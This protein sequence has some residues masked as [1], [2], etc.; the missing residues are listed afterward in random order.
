[1]KLRK[2][3]AQT[4]TAMIIV[5][6]FAAS[7]LTV[8]AA[9]SKTEAVGATSGTTGDCKW[10]L[11]NG[12]LT[13]SGD[14]AMKNY[15]YNNYLPW[16]NEVKS[17]I[18]ENG[19]T[20]IGRSVFYNCRNL[21]SVTIPGSVTSINSDAF[22]NCIGLTSI[23]IPDS[24]TSIGVGAFF[25]C[26][27]LTSVTIPDSVTSIGSAAFG[28]CT[29]LTS[30]TIPDSVT[31]IGG[32]AFYGT[33]W[34]NNQQDGLVYA[35]KAAYEYKGDMPENTSIVIKNG[36]KDISDYAFENCAGLTSITI[37]NGVTSI[38]VEA[39]AFCT[40]LTSVIIPDSVTS[41]GANSFYGCTGMISVTIP[42]RVTNI[43]NFAFGYFYDNNDWMQKKL[44]GFTIYGYEGSE[45]QK[46]AE[47]N[48]FKFVAC[49]V[50]LQI[51]IGDTNG[52][53]KIDIND[54]TVIQRCMAEYIELTAELEAVADVNGDNKVDINDA[55]H[56][57]KYLAE[58]QGV[59]LGK[60]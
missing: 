52:D 7:P 34:F 8:S 37:P 32:R 57:Q 21:T 27:G 40:D 36:T 38:G 43:G 41:I 55:T 25:G 15:S 56:L 17:V 48:G 5:S 35:G 29:G 30:I 22:A 4:L 3:L 59:V 44:D 12:V 23:S 60:Q 13:I 58:F 18:I 33:A 39:F 2:I 53:D 20:I 1:M 10:T 16:R 6:A 50:P 47:D 46:Y 45:A 26:N 42:D 28:D 51:V 11:D 54:V 19:V 9:E 14:G 49:E 31:S 24:V